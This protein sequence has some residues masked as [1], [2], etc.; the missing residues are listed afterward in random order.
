MATELQ[1]RAVDN[2]VVNGGNVTKAMRDA[3]YSENTVNTPKKLTASKG[4]KE[5]CEKNGLTPNLIT[6]SLVEDIKKKK[7]KRLGE[8]SLGADILKMKES[9][10]TGN[11]IIIIQIAQEAAKKY[12][13]NPSS[14]TSN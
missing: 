1:K 6:K 13:I 11:Q 2:L 7:G 12:G 10:P 14:S 4:F 3:K 9:D 5:I 8:L